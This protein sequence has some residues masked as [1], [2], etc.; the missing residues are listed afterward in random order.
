[1]ENLQFQPFAIHGM[2]LM[3]LAIVYH[4]N[5]LF[6]CGCYLLVFTFATSLLQEKAI[7]QGS[8]HK[9]CT[10]IQIIYLIPPSLSLLHIIRK[11]V[12]SLKHNMRTLLVRLMCLV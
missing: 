1:M 7:I 10:L 5:M 11:R 8:I 12:M 9:V 3:L 2:S 4:Q 6:P